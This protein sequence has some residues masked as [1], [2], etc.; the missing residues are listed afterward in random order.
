MTEG[1]LTERVFRAPGADGQVLARRFLERLLWTIMGVLTVGVAAGQLTGMAGW[2]AV[3]LVTLVDLAGAGLLLLNRLERTRLA[4]GLLIALAWAV[5]VSRAVMAGGLHSP[6]PSALILIAVAAGLLLSYRA[7]AWSAVVLCLT[8]VGIAVA[9]WSELLPA[10]PL[11]SARGTRPLTLVATVCGICAVQFLAIRAVRQAQA[12]SREREDLLARVLE[13]LPVG[14]WFMDRTGRLVHRNQAAERIWGGG[15]L[16]GPDGYGEYK[17]RRLDTGEAIEP[18]EWAGARAITHGE[19]TPAEEVEIECFDGSRKAILNSAVPLRDKSGAIAGA[20]VVNQDITARRAAEE[21]GR[22]HAAALAALHAAARVLI[23][24]LDPEQLAKD[25]ARAC[26]EMFGASVAWVGLA[27]ADGSVEPLAQYPPAPAARVPGVVRWDGRRG[28]DGPTGSAIRTAAPA[29]AHGTATD[30]PPGVWQ[31]WALGEGLQ[32][33]AS[34]PLISRGR[35]FGALTLYSRDPRYGSAERL[36]ILQTYAHEVA[37]A[38][39]NARLYDE[40]ERNLRHVKALRKI[41]R[42]ISGSL[43]LRVSLD[44]LLDQVRTEL[45]VDAADILLLDRRTLLLEY[46]AGDGFVSSAAARTA[47]RLGEDCAGRAALEQ[48]TL[49]ALDVGEE[50]HARWTALAAAEQFAWRAAA[51]LLTKGE[52]RGV[53]EVFQRNWFQPDETWSGFLEAVAGQAALAVESATLFGDLQ[54][55]NLELRLAY[56]ATIEGWSRALELRDLET[57]GHSLRVSALS[58]RLARALGMPED[59]IVHLRRGALL[60]DIGKVAVPD[61]VLFKEGPLTEEEWEAMRKHTT[62]ALALLSPIR[63]LRPALDVPFAHHERWDGSG[64]PRGRKGEQIPLAARI[65]AVVDVWDALRSDRPYRPAWPADK[66]RE[67]ISVR[68][69]T[70]FDPAIVKAFLALDPVAEGAPEPATG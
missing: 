63:Y 8:A 16:V 61:S 9:E 70:H 39:T 58:E 54:R 68:A 45:R 41:D 40:T 51:P 6:V 26:V 49:T 23:G 46:A 28:D 38:M 13:N 69:G 25:V 66:V 35:P 7:G 33:A 24:T 14:V 65:F 11:P 5:V 53:L 37:A 3:G 59:D 42:A 55:S 12:R 48:R 29:Q 2:W 56:D 20:I 30:G 44:T 50:A 62:H 32:C 1:T 60:H 31:R 17:A 4:S 34:F 15:R 43:D 27:R 19:T 52:V 57:E 18:H 64:Y 22:E 21:A 10:A 36:E 67:Y 47:L